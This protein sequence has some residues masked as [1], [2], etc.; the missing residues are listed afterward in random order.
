[1]KLNHRNF[2]IRMAVLISGII[3]CIYNNVGRAAGIQERSQ[4]ELMI[5]GTYLKLSLYN[6]A[7]AK[8]Y[9]E[10]NKT[11]YDANSSLRFEINE[12]HNGPLSEIENQDLYSLATKGKGNIIEVIPHTIEYTSGSEAMITYEAKWKSSEYLSAVSPKKLTI[13]ELKMISPA[14]YADVIR[15]TSYKVTVYLNGINRDYKALVDR[16]SVV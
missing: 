10:L 8:D 7:A 4:E 14:K 15:Y 13:E 2:S 1:M 6:A 5:K 12:I 16:K 11:T 9:A 3:F